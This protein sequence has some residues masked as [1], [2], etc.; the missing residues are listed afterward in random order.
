[1]RIYLPRLI[2]VFCASCLWLAHGCQAR[3]AEPIGQF[4]PLWNG[5]APGATGSSDEDTPAVLPFLPDAKLNTGAAILICPGGGF[6]TRCTDFEGV[7]VARWFNARGIAGFVLRYRIRPLYNVDRS[8][9][10]AQRA[11][12]SLRAH[13]SEYHIAPRRIGIIGFS[14]GAELAALASFKTLPGDAKAADVVDREPSRPDFLVLGYGSADPRRGVPREG[15]ATASKFP[16]AGMPPTFMFCTGEDPGHLRGMLDLYDLLRKARVEAEVHFFAHGEHGVG[17]AQGDPVLGEWPN[18]MFNWIRAGGF[19][20]DA[21]RVTIKG[22]VKVDGEAL[23]RG[24]VIFTPIDAPGAPPIVGRV[25]NTG[26]VRGQFALAR[27][28][29]PT[30]GKYRV[31][32]RQDATRWLSNSRD[33]MLLEMSRKQRDGTLTDSDRARWTAYARQKNLSP[34]IDD[35]RIYRHVHPSDAQD[36][37]VEVKPAGDE[38]LAI[39]VFSH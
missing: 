21:Q 22:I 17:F 12:R 29:G 5:S 25:F 36:L 37:I 35:Q 24:V 34:S 26:P 20:T 9:Q 15:D 10:D 39:E 31:E 19:L 8:L 16:A 7:E 3:A 2:V 14:A 30:P 18:L 32:V 1:M 33:P 28:Q 11:M 27:E 23:P 6:T 38:N 13:A 4:V